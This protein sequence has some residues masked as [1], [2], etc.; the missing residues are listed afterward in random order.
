MFT[1]VAAER[2]SPR[3]LEDA[4][5]SRTEARGPESSSMFAQRPRIETSARP[6]RQ[7][8]YHVVLH[9]DDDHTYEYVIDMLRKLFGH[10]FVEAYSLA[11]EVDDTGSA[12]VDTTTLERAELKQD[13]IHSFGHDW[14]LQCSDGAMTCTIEP[15]GT[16]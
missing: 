7:P 4:G 15:T 11:A 1:M 3:R 5:M 10:T 9:D 13:Q 16:G 14:R 2:R 12:I 6:K 8:P